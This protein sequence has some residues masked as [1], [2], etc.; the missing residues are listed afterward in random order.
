MVTFLTINSH[1]VPFPEAGAPEIMTFKGG[2]FEEQLNFSPYQNQNSKH[3]IS[4]V[5]QERLLLS[6]TSW[7]SVFFFIHKH[8]TCGWS[9]NGHCCRH[10]ERDGEKMAHV[11]KRK[12]MKKRE[13]EERWERLM[14]WSRHWWIEYE[15]AKWASFLWSL[16]N[17]EPD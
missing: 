10:A 5:V 4:I 12:K 3:T 16:C 14:E 2:S 7:I 9:S 1:C 13:G 8:W 6:N 17:H 11:T 15:R